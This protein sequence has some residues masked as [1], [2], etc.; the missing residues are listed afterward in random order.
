[1]AI[2]LWTP[3][4]LY[5]IRSDDRMRELPSWILDTYFN[6]TYYSEDQTIKFA[7]LPESD[8]FLAPFVLPYD[9]GKALDVRHGYTVQDFSPPYIKLKNPVRPEDARIVNPLQLINGQRPGLAER[10]DMRTVQITEQHLRSIRVREI[11]MA[12]RAFIDGKVLIEYE[13]DQGAS[14]PSVLLDFG[15]DSGQTIT[16]A[17][18]SYWDD[19]DYDILGDV[20]TWSNLMY[21]SYR[22]GA[23]NM[24]VVGAKVAPVF[25]RN[26]G[27]KDA[28]DTRYRG[29]DSVQMNLGVQRL[30]RPFTFIGALASGLEVWTYKDT[31]DIPNGSGGK[32]KIDI[33]NEKDVLM[34]A[35]GATGV[36]AYGAIYDVD[37][38]EGGSVSVDIFPK[39]FRTSDPGELYV[40]HQSS[41]LPIPL[42]PNRTLKAHV[43]A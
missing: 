24:I 36:R 27:I 6:Q 25:K 11:W 18:P 14:N 3:E 35:P 8:R 26:K 38:I 13:R 21:L 19:P 39:M 22:G 7:D 42:Y 37:A 43:L 20:E 23:P 16:L 28:L 40:M 10:F 29:N 12:A 5:A 31:I 4:D 30:E 9:Q 1:M 15:R 41:P 33:L 2:D 17:G 32:T 34:V